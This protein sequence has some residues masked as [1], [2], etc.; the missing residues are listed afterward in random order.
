FL[1][2]DAEV[3]GGER[4]KVLDFGIAKLAGELQAAGVH[5]RTNIVMGTPSYMSPEQCR[6]GGAVD[7][8]ADI[9]SLGCILFKIC[10]GRPPF[11]GQGPGEIVG[12]HLHVAPPQLQSLAPEMPAELGALVAR[13]LEKQPEARPQTMT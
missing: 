7:P 3:T 8:R 2:P 6:G 1:V 9:Y 13:M 12:A 4:V 5:T 10:C 11:L